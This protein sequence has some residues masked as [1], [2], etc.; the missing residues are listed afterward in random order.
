MAKDK[1][2]DKGEIVTVSTAE[3]TTMK[4]LIKQVQTE[5]Q[6]A[7]DNQ[8]QKKVSDRLRLKLYNNQKRDPKAVGDTTLF[9]TM[10]TVVA[11]LYSDKLTAE[12]GGREEGD[13]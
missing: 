11:S 1:E 12:W 3:D 10:Q 6:L 5:W 2:D 7:W 9:T 13:F 8:Q 4:Q